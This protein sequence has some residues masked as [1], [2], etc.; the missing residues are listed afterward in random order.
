MFHTSSVM[1][2]AISANRGL[3][4]KA[5]GVLCWA[6]WELWGGRNSPSPL[7]PA[8]LHLR[9]HPLLARQDSEYS[10][11]LMAR[12]AHCHQQGSPKLTWRCLFVS[13]NRS[14]SPPSFSVA[15]T[16]SLTTLTA[17]SLASLALGGTVRETLLMWRWEVTHKIYAVDST[18]SHRSIP[19]TS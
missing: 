14:P 8:L 19:L 4:S 2:L 12:N 5:S 11:G 16:T 6:L 3:E 18:V 10:P 9:R 17:P 15:T 13:P 7:Q 1:C